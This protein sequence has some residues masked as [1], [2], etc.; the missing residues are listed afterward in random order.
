[1]R[2]LSLET[3]EEFTSEQDIY[4]YATEHLD[5]F[6]RFVR[7]LS[8]RE[9]DLIM[10]YYLLGTTQTD[11]GNIFGVTQ[12]I[13]SSQLR[14]IVRAFGALVMFQG[15][16]TEQQL[17]TILSSAGY[18]TVLMNSKHE[19]ITPPGAP[20]QGGHALRPDPQL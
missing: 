12:T 2:T 19:R 4:T 1:V 6:I 8:K 3:C 5:Q 11:L 7:F 16:P 15:E 10:A 20:L 13:C 14:L 17:D 18:A 9:Q